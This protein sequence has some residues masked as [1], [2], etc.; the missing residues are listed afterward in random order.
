[1]P[2]NCTAKTG[3]QNAQ[4]GGGDNA[5]QN[6][7]GALRG[8]QAGGGKPDDNGIVAG[9]HQVDHDDLAEGGERVGCNAEELAHGGA[10][11]PSLISPT[12]QPH[13]CQRGPA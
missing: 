7:A 12:S 10:G 1:M 2:S 9:Q 5:D 4:H 6:G 8:R 13:G 11:P 3:E